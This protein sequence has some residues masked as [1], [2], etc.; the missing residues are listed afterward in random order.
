MEFAKC[1]R[2]YWALMPYLESV[3]VNASSIIT[4]SQYLDD[5]IDKLFATSGVLLTETIQ[6]GAVDRIEVDILS[7]LK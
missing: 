4:R 1:T 3:E 7:R 5:N 6:T 2:L